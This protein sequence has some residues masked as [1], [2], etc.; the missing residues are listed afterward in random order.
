[1]SRRPCCAVGA[2][3]LDLA[4]ELSVA[5]IADASVDP[6]EEWSEMECRV[7]CGAC[8]VAP[9]ITSPIPGMPAGK[10][11]SVRCAQLTGD[12]R[13]RLFGRPERPAF[14]GT[15]RPSEDMCGRNVEEAMAR[16]AEM[17]AKTDPS[18]P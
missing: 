7:G 17:E 4:S 5:S 9:S 3:Q 14:C 10:P 1:M 18:A 2:L 8:C 13:C 16:L 15:L 6:C 12:N 11:A